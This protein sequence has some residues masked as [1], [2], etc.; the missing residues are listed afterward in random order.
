MQIKPN[1]MEMEN[2]INQRIAAIITELGMNPKTFA[3]SLNKTPTAIYTIL[4]G[5]NKPG[6]DIL[7]A[8]LLVYPEISP[9]YLMR[10]EGEIMK[11][12]VEKASIGNSFGS[13][14]VEKILEEFQALKSQL[15]IKDRQIDGLQRTS[16]SLQR[17]I[18]VLLTSRQP[19]DKTS[20]R[21][22]VLG[23]GSTKPAYQGWVD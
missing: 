6:Y 9:T 20:F 11:V 22:P 23:T 12:E 5:S 19:A 21:N 1:S 3:E 15:S 17:T 2:T 16:E 4:K 10:G 13:Q 7:E 14:V 18:D 8:I